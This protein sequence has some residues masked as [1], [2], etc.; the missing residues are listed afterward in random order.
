MSLL[1]LRISGVTQPF[2]ASILTFMRN[3]LILEFSIYGML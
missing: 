3:T 2:L 1:Y